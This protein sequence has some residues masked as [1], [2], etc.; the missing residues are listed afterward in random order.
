[1]LF[2]GVVIGVGGVVVFGGGDFV[3][4]VC[5]CVVFYVDGIGVFS[6]LLVDVGVGCF[7]EILLWGI[8]CVVVD[9]CWSCRDGVRMCDSV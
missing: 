1:M 7:V 3:L 8:C 6:F 4:L 2:D 5:C 9:L